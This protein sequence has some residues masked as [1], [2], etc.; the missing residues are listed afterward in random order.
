MFSGGQ[1]TDWYAEGLPPWKP[2][3]L[4]QAGSRQ[5]T[6]RMAQ[7]F[8]AVIEASSRHLCRYGTMPA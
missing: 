6:P 8:T 2:E 3:S 4:L 1:G 5:T 7:S